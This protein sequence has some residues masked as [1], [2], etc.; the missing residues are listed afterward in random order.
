MVHEIL[1]KEW[2]RYAEMDLASAKVLMETM[3]PPPLEIICYHCQ[4]AAE[5]CLK[6]LL[7]A[8]N[9]DIEKT[10]DLVRL[11]NKLEGYKPVPDEI[12]DIAENLTQFSTRTRYPQES[13]VDTLQTTLA[14]AQ[15]ERLLP[16]A[17]GQIDGT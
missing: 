2:F 5:K 15:A 11:L 6:G 14:I 17:I 10:H 13:C 12:Y 4:Q 9:D 1:V 8:V 3:Y 16:W 7:L